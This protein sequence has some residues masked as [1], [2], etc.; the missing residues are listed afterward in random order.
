MKTNKIK[1]ANLLLGVSILLVIISIIFAA[2]TIFSPGT[3]DSWG[4]TGFA[5]ASNV[6]SAKVNLS[7]TQGVIINFTID[8][9]QWGVGAV[10]T[11]NQN[12]TL[13]TSQPAASKVQR[14]TWNETTGESGLY[15]RTNGLILENMGNVNVTLFLKTGKNASNFI[16]GTNPSYMFNITNNESNSCTM[17]AIDN[18][19]LGHYY[20]VNATVNGSGSAFTRT[21]DGTRICSNFTPYQSSDAIKIDI[22]LRIPSDSLTNALTDTIT[23]TAFQT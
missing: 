10:S 4:L 22:Y 3:L 18:F 13:D 20:E 1:L 14:G 19:T 8:T 6:T 7:V 5:T 12:A 15:N 9:I 2:L 17:N 21:G 11:G 23:V 16:G